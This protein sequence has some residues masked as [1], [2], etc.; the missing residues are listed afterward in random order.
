M[1]NLHFTSNIMEEVYRLKR[2]YRVLTTEL[3]YIKYKKSDSLKKFFIFLAFCFQ[4]FQ[5]KQNNYYSSINNVFIMAK[6]SYKNNPKSDVIVKQATSK[7]YFGLD[8]TV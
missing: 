2:S 8:P 4:K 1:K 3:T 5:N 6:I 7:L